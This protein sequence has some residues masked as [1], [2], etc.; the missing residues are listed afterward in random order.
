MN[1]LFSEL[2]D[3]RGAHAVS[4][5]FKLIRVVR[6]YVI[7]ITY[8]STKNAKTV[9]LAYSFYLQFSTYDLC[10]IIGTSHLLPNQ[11]L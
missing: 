2:F 10:A 6:V 4:K 7:R 9:F 5:K 1:F 3:F 8:E 11:Y